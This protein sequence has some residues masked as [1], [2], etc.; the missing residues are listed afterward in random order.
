MH[1]FPEVML[2]YW[3]TRMLSWWDLILA[4]LKPSLAGGGKPVFCCCFLFFHGVV[5]WRR[6]L[7]VDFSSYHL[8]V[9]EMEEPSPNP[10]LRLISLDWCVNQ[11][12]IDF[13]QNL[14]RVTVLFADTNMAFS[15]H[16]QLSW[17]WYP[18][19]SAAEREK[20][21]RHNSTQKLFFGSS[22]LDWKGLTWVSVHKIPVLRSKNVSTA[23]YQLCHILRNPS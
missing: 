19:C 23:L 12:P 6:F 21:K 10:L 4:C 13:Y 16:A 5:K 3:K 18:L 9:T 20:K 15:K 1:H 8:S 14:S 22:I 7:T 17:A 2:A 11:F